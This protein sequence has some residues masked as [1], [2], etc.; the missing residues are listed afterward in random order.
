MV[1][2]VFVIGII[3]GITIMAVISANRNFYYYELEKRVREQV[4]EKIGNYTVYKEILDE[5]YGKNNW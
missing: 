5:M 1:L 3:L 2:A 4:R